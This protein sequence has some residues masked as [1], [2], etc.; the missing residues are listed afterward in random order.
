MGYVH[1][2]I[3]HSHKEEQNYIIFREMEL[4]NI[5]LS[6]ISQSQK[7]KSWMFSL[8]SRR[9]GENGIGGTPDKGRE[10]LEE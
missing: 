9:Y 1:N 8:I 6:G 7:V 10:R 5:T 3:L 4:E 2:G